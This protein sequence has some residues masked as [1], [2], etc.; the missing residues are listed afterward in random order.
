MTGQVS[1]PPAKTYDAVIPAS[2]R[3]TAPDFTLTDVHGMPL[4]LS[5]YKG[6]VVLLDFWATTCGGCKVEL[7]W[8]VDFDHKYRDQGLSVIGLDMYGESADVIR[9]FMTKWKMDYPVAIGTDAIG[10]QF[11]LSEMPLTLLI[12]RGGKIAVAHAGIVDRAAFESDIKKLLQQR[13]DAL[14]SGQRLRLKMWP[15]TFPRP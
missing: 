10:D 13:P 6:R 12:D 5:K 1:A 11:K 15:T 7:P 9:P 4:T 3:I 8:Y 2:A 14:S